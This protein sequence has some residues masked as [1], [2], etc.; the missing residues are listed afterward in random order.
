MTATRPLATQV[1]NVGQR[2]AKSYDCHETVRPSAVE[3]GFC[4]ARSPPRDATSRGGPRSSCGS[5]CPSH[6][7]TNRRWRPRSPRKPRRAARA[8]TCASAV[9]ARVPTARTLPTS[10]CSG[11]AIATARDASSGA[12]LGDI[13]AHH[14]RCISDHQL[15]VPDVAVRRS[16]SN[17]RFHRPEHVDTDGDRGIRAG[18]E[19]PP[20]DTRTI[21]R[22]RGVGLMGPASQAGR[23]PR[24]G[25]PAHVGAVALPLRLA[26]PVPAP[27]ADK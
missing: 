22:R 18:H 17:A 4:R 24:Y 16:P 5:R 2:A 3:G 27:L 11:T 1:G 13:D 19:Q 9:T 15:R 21:V 23:R 8:G 25:D 7:R 10:M 20:A 26:Q 14:D 6:A 12:Q